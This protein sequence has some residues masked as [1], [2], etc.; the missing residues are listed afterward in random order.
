MSTDDPRLH[1]R[2]ET[3]DARFEGAATHVALLHTN[4]ILAFGGSAL[5]PEALP[6]P[7]PAELLDLG[8]LTVRSVS[9]EGVVGDLFCCGHTFLADGT[10]LVVGGTS[11]YQPWWHPFPAGRKE[12]YIFDPATEAWRRLPDIP[13]GRWYPTLIRL[14]DNSVLVIAGLREHFPWFVLRRSQDVYRSGQDWSQMKQKKWFPLY[15]RLHVLPDGDVFYSGVF[16]VHF[17]FPWFFPS[18]R[19]DHRTETWS[20]VG[21]SHLDPQR[22]EGISLLLALR[23]PDYRARILIAGGGHRRHKTALDSAELIDLSQPQPGWVSAGTMRHARIHANGVLL[24]DGTVIVVGG[25]TGETTHHHAV[26]VSAPGA[27]PDAVHEAEMYD[28]D[29]KTWTPLATQAKDRL[30]HSSALLLPDGRV[31]SMG[32]NPD[33]KVIEHSI[34]IYSPPYLF[35]G[36]R[37]QLVAWPERLTY[38]QP[39]RVTVDR[40]RQIGKA[41]LMRP[42]AVTH[43]TNTDQRLLEL[44]FKVLG[45]TS[46]EVQGPP[47]RSHIPEGHALLL[48]LSNDG[49]PSAGRFLRVA[50]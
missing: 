27:D 22:E 43:I 17:E 30:Y 29:R 1:G 40:A 7:A 28:P 20:G 10:L 35:R 26:P 49:V 4:K 25:K 36:D 44:E 32:G 34:E 18:G 33:P 48:V 42:E 15:P 2:W 50:S 39:F 38:A 19:W 13:V 9:M 12:A 45:D 6:H 23:P 11:H 41:V 8:T 5:D 37:P 14:A 47:S 16:N 21:G 31:I 46:L 3:I 24:P